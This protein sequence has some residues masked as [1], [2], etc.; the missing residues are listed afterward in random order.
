[1][2]RKVCLNQNLSSSTYARVIHGSVVT[3]STIYLP[4]ADRLVLGSFGALGSKAAGKLRRKHYQFARS[5][6]ILGMAE[7]GYTKMFFVFN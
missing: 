7:T 4:G 3:C 1:M 2:L 6:S 5:T